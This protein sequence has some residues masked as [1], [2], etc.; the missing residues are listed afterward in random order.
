MRSFISPLFMPTV[1]EELSALR[2]EV[3][4]E[5]QGEVDKW[6]AV[7]EADQSIGVL[8]ANS[9]ICLDNILKLLDDTHPEVAERLQA[10]HQQILAV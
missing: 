2:N 3:P 1:H 10:C 9:G 7:I 8:I 5:A 4:K 6:L